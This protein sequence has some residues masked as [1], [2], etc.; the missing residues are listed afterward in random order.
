M[1]DDKVAGHYG[2]DKTE[3]L[4]RRD[5]HWPGLRKWIG[6]Y[7]GSCD[8]CQRNRRPRAKPVG[9]LAPLPLAGKPWQSIT[10]D[11]ITD[12]PES[13]GLDSILVIVDRFSKRAHFVPCRKDNDAPALAELFVREY[14]RLHGF[15]EQIISDRGTLFTSQ[16]W[17]DVCR[18]TGVE[19]SF[20][21]AFHPQTDGQTERSNSTLEQYLRSYVNFQQY[22]W[23]ELLP[24]AE[25]AYNNSKH[26]AI[27]MSPFMASEGTHHR[28][29]F[30]RDLTAGET[31]TEYT[32]RMNNI[33]ES[34]K[35][36][37]EQAREDMAKYANRKRQPVP[38]TGYEVGDMVMLSS[39]HVNTIRP[40]KK[41]EWKS[42]GPFK[43][44]AKIGKAQ[45][46]RKLEL[47]ASMKRMHPVFHVSML[48]PYWGNE[49]DAREVGA[50]P[51]PEVLENGETAWVVSEIVHSKEVKRGRGRRVQY[52]VRYEGYA[53]E[54]NEWVSPGEFHHDDLVVVDFH[55][56]Y[57]RLPTPGRQEYGDA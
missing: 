36:A 23:V 55:K 48:T 14:V 54:H 19:N 49:L 20:S 25:F 27:G 57:P 6:D 18:I 12:L 46:A 10:W 53:D 37:L 11:H 21:T 40:S 31:A 7:V 50:P 28:I 17:K 38:P 34:V 43:I 22:D 1:H 33:F 9:E 29:S 47:P 16:F 5:F 41:L 30:R 26:S 24:M 15:P 56:R 8:V 2:R 35:R 45:M 3:D 52:Y 4:V 42:F 39:K 32:D 51:P 44:V 13:R